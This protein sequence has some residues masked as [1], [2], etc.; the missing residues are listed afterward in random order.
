M[1]G[2]SQVVVSASQSLSSVDASVW[3]GRLTSE[4]SPASKSVADWEGSFFAS[5][6][7]KTLKQN[8]GIGRKF[9]NLVGPGLRTS[10]ARTRLVWDSGGG[11]TH[12]QLMDTHLT[13]GWPSW[14]EQW[15]FVLHRSSPSPAWWVTALGLGICVQH[16][17]T[18]P[19]PQSPNSHHRGVAPGHGLRCGLAWTPLTTLIPCQVYGPNKNGRKP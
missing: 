11:T 10:R 7:L 5:D 19:V 3:A 9:R 2:L 1:A 16:S 4:K 12:L 13:C 17:C 18:I 8:L 14:F 15:V 6:D